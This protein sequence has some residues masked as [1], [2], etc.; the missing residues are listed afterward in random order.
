VLAPLLKDLRQRLH[1]SGAHAGPDDI[2]RGG[3]TGD[4]DVRIC[5]EHAEGAR[6]AGR[7]FPHLLV[8]LLDGL[9]AFRDQPIHI[10]GPIGDIVACEVAAASTEVAVIVDEQILDLRA[11]YQ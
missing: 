9:L 6:S 3:V 8:E 10:Q 1:R 7:T 4:D 5:K 2:C 11:I